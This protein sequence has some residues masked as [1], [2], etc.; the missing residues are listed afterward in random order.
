MNRDSYDDIP[1]DS[2]PI[3]ETHPAHLALLGTLFGAEPAPAARC[4]YLELGCASGGN[5]IPLAVALPDSEFVGIERSAGQAAAGRALIARLGLRNVRIEEADL[6]DVPDAVLGTFDYIVAHGFYSWVPEA[7]R[8]R[9]WRLCAATLAPQGIAYLSY[10]VYPGWRWRGMVRDLLRY[11]VRGLETP[12]ARLE[13]AREAIGQYAAA[14]TGRSDAPSV[15]LREELLQLDTRHPSYLY[16]EYLVDENTPF[17]FSEV[18]AE[19][20]RH[21]LQ[22]LCETELHTM[23][24]D[25]LGNAAEALVDAAADIVAQEQVMDFLR[26]R[27]FRQTLLCRSAVSLNR[28]LELERFAALAYHASLVPARAVD[29]KRFDDQSFRT[30]EGARCQVRQPLTRAALLELAEVYPDAVAFA[31]LAARAEQRV[32]RAGGTD[33]DR[34][35]FLVELLR[36]FLHQYIGA[37]PA[38]ESVPRSD[39][40]RPCVSALAR[41]QAACGLGHVATVR[42]M[43]MALDAFATRLIGYLDGQRSRGELLTLLKDDLETGRLQLDTGLPGRQ[44]PGATLSAN[45]DRMLDMLA[46][47]GILVP[48]TNHER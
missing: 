35:A 46:R 33:R 36:L 1:Y 15:M 22:Y 39:P 14:L 29:L 26:N 21:G 4:R 24:P 41:A 25:G 34:Q 20:G 40:A 5:L 18:M 6:L 32:R 19:A 30:P 8:A 11:H 10:N 38:A 13:A 48:V 44:V 7:V 23:F 12:R 37:A 9:T 27:L 3:H 2:A 45:L 31:D 16:H 28:E 17:L 42:H 43:P 47:Q